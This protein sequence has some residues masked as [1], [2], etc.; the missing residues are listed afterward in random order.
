MRFN[1]PEIIR[2]KTD[3]ILGSARVSGDTISYIGLMEK[4]TKI[5]EYHIRKEVEGLMGETISHQRALMMTAHKVYGILDMF[6]KIPPTDEEHLAELITQ[7]RNY[8][9]WASDIKVRFFQTHSGKVEINTRIPSFGE[10]GMSQQEI[11][12]ILDEVNLDEILE[13]LSMYMDIGSP[14]NN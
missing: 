14:S 2:T 12:D 5:L 13:V 4:C 11:Q 7:S 8:E 1:H 10:E 9:M 6:E 3:V